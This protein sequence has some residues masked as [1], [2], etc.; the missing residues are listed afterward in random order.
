VAAKPAKVKYNE[1][2]KGSFSNNEMIF[3]SEPFPFKKDTMAFRSLTFTNLS[4]I[5]L[6]QHGE[7]SKDNGQHW[8]TEFDLE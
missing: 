5:K 6:R 4:A 7:I 2:L 1:Y 8:Q 3:T